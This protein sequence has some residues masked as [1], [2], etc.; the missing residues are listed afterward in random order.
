LRFKN[1]LAEI[2][3]PIGDLH[4]LECGV[5]KVICVM[6]FLWPA[7]DDEPGPAS[8][9]G[10]IERNAIALLSNYEKAPL[11]PA[12]SNWLGSSCNRERVRKSGLWNSNH[13][14]EAHDPDFLNQL[15]PLAP[16]L[17]HKVASGEREVRP[18]LRHLC[19]STSPECGL[20]SRNLG[21]LI[22]RAVPHEREGESQE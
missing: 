9:R 21:R 2:G 22:A 10:Y 6:P 4:V 3:K 17:P 15:R 5:S 8:L 16:T 12:S 11:D 7:I 20:G 19:A 14:D 18:S 13:V 1:C